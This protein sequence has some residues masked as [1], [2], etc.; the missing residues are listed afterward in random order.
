MQLSVCVVHA[1]RLRKLMTGFAIIFALKRAWG[2]QKMLSCSVQPYNHKD[3]VLKCKRTVTMQDKHNLAEKNNIISI[4]A[5][6]HTS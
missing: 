5:F 1:A 6:F 4:L 3:I 2:A